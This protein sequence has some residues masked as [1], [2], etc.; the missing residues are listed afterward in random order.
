MAMMMGDNLSSRDDG[1]GIRGQGQ[2]YVIFK[3]IFLAVVM[4]ISMGDGFS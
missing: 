3:M 1:V 2:H 4:L